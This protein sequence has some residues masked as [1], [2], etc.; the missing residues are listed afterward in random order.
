MAEYNRLGYEI[1]YK[2]T[3]TRYITDGYENEDKNE[4]FINA[5]GTYRIFTKTKL[6]AEFDYGNIAYIKTFNSDANFYQGLVGIR[7]KLTEKCTAE[8]KGGW[9][10]R[11]YTRATTK[12]YDGLVTTAS[13]QEDFTENDILKITWLRTPFESL[14]TGTN[15]Y[16]AN[17]VTGMYIHKFTEKFSANVNTSYQLSTYPTETTEDSETRKR[18]DS[19]WSIGAG[20]EYAMQKW[21]IC[22]AGYEF[23]QRLSNFD[24]FEFNDNLVT[25]SLHL[26]Y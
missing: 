8:I 11:D 19:T 3:I 6:L 7:G 4:N 20:V 10:Y 2:N 23:R 9:Q 24:K 18:Q 22:R 17:N 16:V 5:I 15:Y 26:M 21:A 25:A 14:Y 1:F 13:I 12:D